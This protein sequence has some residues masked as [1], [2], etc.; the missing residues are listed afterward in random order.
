MLLYIICLFTECTLN[1]Y[2]SLPKTYSLHTNT[3][4]HKHWKLT[5]KT[6]M[7]SSPY[8]HPLQWRCGLELNRNSP[9]YFGCFGPITKTLWLCTVCP[10]EMCCQVRALVGNL[11]QYQGWLWQWLKVIEEKRGAKT[12]RTSWCFQWVAES[13]V[14]EVTSLENRIWAE[15][16]TPVL[17]ETK[18][19][20]IKVEDVSPFS[21]LSAGLSSCVRLLQLSASLTR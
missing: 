6:N 3:L 21:P 15:S 18:A 17:G 11:L 19:R 1:V 9:V 13:H 7:N 20:G 16:Q 10:S 4:P 2:N 8:Q 12:N 14:G 5:I